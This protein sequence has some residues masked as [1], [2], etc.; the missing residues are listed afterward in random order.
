MLLL[1]SRLRIHDIPVLLMLLAMALPSAAANTAPITDEVSQASTNGVF[2]PDA[3]PKPTIQL[4]PHV[5]FGGRIELKSEVERN[6][7]LQDNDEDDLS[8][9]EP[10]L[11]GS[12]SYDPNDR[13]RAFLNMSFQRK[14]RLED[15]GKKKEFEWKILLSQAYLKLKDFIIKNFAVQIGRQ[16]FDDERECITIK[17]G[18][19]CG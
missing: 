17:N 3:P 16:R 11:S 19:R 13:I 8:T 4:I 5:T 14:F 15:E 7:D 6:F 10:K 12:L 2:D 1:G 9:I 18:M